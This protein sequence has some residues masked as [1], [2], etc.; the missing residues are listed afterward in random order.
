MMIML[1]LLQGPDNIHLDP[2]RVHNENNLIEADQDA[3]G[4]AA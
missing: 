4:F 3:R 2:M 1:Y